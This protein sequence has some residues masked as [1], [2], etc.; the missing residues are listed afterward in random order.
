MSTVA[1]ALLEE[2]LLYACEPDEAC[3]EAVTARIHALQYRRVA[4][5]LLRDIDTAHTAALKTVIPLCRYAVDILDG[6][7]DQVEPDQIDQVEPIHAPA[8]PTAR[9]T[10]MEE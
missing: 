9:P 6:E 7:S 1:A 3:F 4:N 2:H 8:H 10:D 5:G